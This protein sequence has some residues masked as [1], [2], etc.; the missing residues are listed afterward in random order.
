MTASYYLLKFFV[1]M[2]LVV[3]TRIFVTHVCKRAG[4][5]DR[6]GVCI[7]ESAVAFLLTRLLEALYEDLPV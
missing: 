7:S 5:M 3:T 4:K 1:S 6:L 2:I